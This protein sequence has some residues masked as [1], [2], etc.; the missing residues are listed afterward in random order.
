MILVPRRDLFRFALAT[1]ILVPALEARAA[2][3]ADAGGFVRG[4]ISRGLSIL[5]DPNA[6]QAD[7]ERAFRSLF[8]QSF[9]VARIS[10]FVLGRYWRIASDEEKTQFTHIYSAFVGHNLAVQLHQYAGETVSVTG[11]RPEG[12]V[13]MVATTMVRPNSGA[14]A[15]VNWRV[16]SGPAGFK[17]VD[18]DVEG[19]SMLLSQRQE[20]ASIIQ[21][22]GGTV[23]GLTRAIHQ[24]MGG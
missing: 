10:R 17:I 8:E 13:T 12:D 4:V 1:L 24:K 19:I 14:P 20:F 9:D 18:V 6:R 16:G 21:H 23:A 7:R 22:N 2:D 5:A 11:V 3:I 15:K